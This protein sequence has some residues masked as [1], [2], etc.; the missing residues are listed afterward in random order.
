MQYGVVGQA[1]G[2]VFRIV[3]IERSFELQVAL[4]AAS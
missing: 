3:L 1:A 2:E 4:H